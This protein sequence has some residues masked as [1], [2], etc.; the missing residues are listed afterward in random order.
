ML[1]ITNFQTCCFNLVNTL[2]SA[3]S[4]P[5]NFR[6]KQQMHTNGMPLKPAGFHN[7]LLYYSLLIQRVLALCELNYCNFHC[8]ELSENSWNIRLMFGRMVN[9]RGK[10]WYPKV[11]SSNTSRLEAHIGFFRL[12]MKGIFYPYVPFDKKMIS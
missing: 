8:C 7:S 11:A 3:S 10:C 2:V 9:N 4:A 5:Q 12:L 6:K 1:W